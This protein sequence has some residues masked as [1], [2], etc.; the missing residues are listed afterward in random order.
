MCPPHCECP[1]AVLVFMLLGLL[2]RVVAPS[3]LELTV[4]HC[5]WLRGMGPT[6]MWEQMQV[7]LFG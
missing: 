5:W 1:N 7:C 2:V 6:S 4:N 3:V